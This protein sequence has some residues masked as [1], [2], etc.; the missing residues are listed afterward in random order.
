MSSDKLATPLIRQ[1]NS[2]KANYP[3]YILLFRLGD[4][5]ETFN[6]DAEITSQVF[7]IALTR[8][9]VGKDHYVPL[10]GIPYHSLDSYLGKL[11]RAGYKVAI[12]EQVEDPRKAKGIVKREVL[13]VVTPGTVVEDSILEEKQNNYLVAICSHKD[14]W[15]LAAVD[16]STGSFS[17]AEYA[18]E[19]A[20][21]DILGTIVR[22]QPAEILFPEDGKEMQY[23]G[24]ELDFNFARTPLAKDYFSLESARRD[25]CEH[26]KVHNLEGFGA[27]NHST[28]L[29]AAGAT[30]K[31]LKETQKT[32]L[33]HI[34][35]LR[36]Y[37][38]H[39]YMILDPS[40]QISL[41]LVRN[42]QDSSR[43]GTLLQILDHTLTSMGARQ[44]RQWIMEPLNA[45]EEIQKRLEGV[46]EL[47]ENVTLK[48]KITV[49]LKGIA[50]I[51][52]I[53]SRI[54][55]RSANARDLV[56]LRYSLEKI[57]QLISVL[58]E[59]SSGILKEIQKNLNALPELTED[60]RNAL[61]DNPPL[62]LKDGGVIRDGYEEKLDE[63]REITRDS[64]GWI[65]RL[66]EKEIKRTG[67]S[68]LKIGFNKV[69]GYY[70][71][72]TKANLKGVENLPDD[73]QR[74]QTL[75]NAERY[76]TTEM[77]EKEEIILDAEEKINILELQLFEDLR[78][79][80]ARFTNEIKATAQAVATLDCLYSLSRAAILGN[81]TK[82][83][84]NNDDRISISDG[85]HPVLEAMELGHPFVPNDTLLD[86]S[87]NQIII[88]TGP[89][90]AGKSTYIRQVALITLMAH[91]GSFVPASKADICIVDR[92]FTRIGARDFLTKGQSTFLVEMS[93]T[94]N[95]LNN[96]TK[97]SLVI[98]DEIGR[99]TS[100]YDGLS[101]AWATVEYLHNTRHSNPKT[102]F[103]T[104]YHEL[105]ELEHNLERVKNFNVAVLE[106]K[107][108]IV[109]LY[110]IVP[111]GTDRSYGIY[112]AELAG[113]PKETVER[114]K[115]ILFHL[116]CGT[117]A[118]A[119]S[120]PDEEKTTKDE[121]ATFGTYQLTLFDDIS[122]PVLEKLRKID[123]E[124]L[125]PIEALNLLDQIV[126]ESKK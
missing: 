40:T 24:V 59:A 32:T 74:K 97:N 19:E 104:H 55:V 2:I 77:K 14:T 22:L 25:L 20:Q 100:T 54:G 13:R 26:L 33:S 43:N 123:V 111:G 126:K 112:A 71:E 8:K 110:K 108:K 57:P 107:D 117:A 50:D 36:V 96:A 10:A 5:Y 94:A 101:I 66:R 45:R 9:R 48:D 85:R 89:N 61:V 80:A 7:N 1:Y 34:N 64:K 121:S 46:E 118:G 115:E 62:T 42:L 79:R 82:P 95:I 106:E 11:I 58:E 4:F 67:V 84:I 73:Y 31:Y 3:K 21:K 105:I 6:E 44:L 120:A 18:S 92:I 30:L 47:Y 116:E 113:V 37:D 109:F 51:E 93:E 90:M 41:E 38:P 17:I 65:N 125:S 56:S 86:N 63:L 60:I 29:M 103:A 122:H 99:G 114:A 81:Y 75:V 88:I 78:E 35:A 28:S 12:C 49:L 39:E 83:S 27:E 16:F 119:D 124:K 70:I 53:N 15:G 87:E 91:I 102:L 68:N 23:L 72:I 52:R 98:L 69:F 76:I